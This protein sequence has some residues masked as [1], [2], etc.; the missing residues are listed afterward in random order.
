MTIM[1]FPLHDGGAVLVRVSDEQATSPV[2]T[3]GASTNAMI[4]RAE[5]TFESVMRAVRAVAYGLTAQVEDFVQRPDVLVVEFGVELNA[6]AGAVITAA[7]ASAQL[8]VSL[9]WNKS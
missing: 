9:T 1:E 7:G 4:E 5:G 2:L 3:R 8:T 6:Q